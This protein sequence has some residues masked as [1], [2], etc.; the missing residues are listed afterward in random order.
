MTNVNFFIGAPQSFNE[1]IEVYPPLIKDLIQKKNFYQMAQCFLISQEDIEDEYVKQN[2]P[3]T[4]MPTPYEYLFNLS[5]NDKELAKL[6]QEAF[7]QFIHSKV[8]FL[9]QLKKI[10][11]GR[12][13]AIIATSSSIDDIKFLE[14]EDYF[15]FQN[16]VRESMGMKAVE[17]YNPLEHPHIREMKAKARY[18][19]R[20]KAKQGVGLSLFSTLSSICCMGIGL[21]PLNIGEL[22]Y[23]A[24][25]ELIDRYQQKEKFDIDLH[26]IWAGA[27][28][29]KHK[30]TP[31]HWIRNL[32][33]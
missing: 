5:Y 11:I 30:I 20:I 22:S 14:E 4:E 29:K 2:I 1:D 9:Y 6:I 19:D 25:C 15:A 12:K 28:Q 23:V 21:N 13:E 18:R 17:P 33:D 26:T 3:L 27:D 8:T 32:E 31:K 24:A 7:K 16:L 10:A